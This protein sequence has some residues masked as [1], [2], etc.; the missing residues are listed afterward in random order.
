MMSLEDAWLTPNRGCPN[1][2]TSDGPE[3]L[4][5]KNFVGLYVIYVATSTICFLLSLTILLKQFQQH[6]DAYQGNASDES[7]WNRT[8]R[9]ARFVYNREF[10]VPSSRTASFV[11][12][13]EMTSSQ[14]EHATT[15]TPQE[16]LLQA[17]TPAQTS[18]PHE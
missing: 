6:Q 8:L 10:N 16:H 17:S 15:S 18:P 5:V 9:M 11:D 13:L 1:N 12:V 3:S 7:V 4:K 2:S 14:W